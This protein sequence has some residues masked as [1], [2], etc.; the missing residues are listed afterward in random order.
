[1]N[2]LKQAQ[3]VIQKMGYDASTDTISLEADNFSLKDSIFRINAAETADGISAPD[4]QCGIEVY[5]GPNLPPAMIYFSE[6]EQCFK[7][8]LSD[9]VREL[10]LSSDVLEKVKLLP[11]TPFD[12]QRYFTESFLGL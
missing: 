4:G 6:T 10:G 11:P 1:M 3:L 7:S 5:R 9:D 2:L 8:N 12:E